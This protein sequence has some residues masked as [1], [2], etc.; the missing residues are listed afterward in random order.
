MLVKF[1][2]P[3]FTA[4]IIPMLWLSFDLP[5]LCIMDSRP[6]FISLGNEITHFQ[7]FTSISSSIYI[8]RGEF[9]FFAA[10]E[11]FI[12]QTFVFWHYVMSWDKPFPSDFISVCGFYFIVLPLTSKFLSPTGI[13]PWISI[14][15]IQPPVCYLHRSAS[16]TS[17]IGPHPSRLT[18]NTVEPRVPSLSLPWLHLE[19]QDIVHK[20]MTPRA[21]LNPSSVHTH[22]CPCKQHSFLLPSLRGCTPM[23]QSPLEVSGLWA[24]SKFSG[25]GT[26]RSRNLR[27]HP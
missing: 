21:G 10:T 11:S 20:C 3:T 17:I 9:L 6:S 23:A 15:C 18:P 14:F 19:L 25:Q 12:Q 2:S 5:C 1:R 7:T 24:G 27:S 4:P 8:Q 26:L 16:Q 13:G 22:T